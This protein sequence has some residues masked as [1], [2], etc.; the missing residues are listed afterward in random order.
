MIHV[1]TFLVCLSGQC[2]LVELPAPSPLVC[3]MTAQQS[4]AAWL[5]QHPG[6]ER[7]GG[8]KCLGGQRA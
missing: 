3:M 4:M 7:R 1:L 5:A 8:W 2:H 6:Y